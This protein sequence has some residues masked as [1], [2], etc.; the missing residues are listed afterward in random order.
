MG[1]AGLHQGLELRLKGLGGR[2]RTLKDR[3]SRAEGLQKIEALGLISRLEGRYNELK[4]RLDELNREGPG[5]RHGMKNELEK[6]TFDLSGALE[7][8]ITWADSG[9]HPDKHPA[10][11]PSSK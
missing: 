9:Y 3:M 10:E 5:F 7:N 2:I 4:D 6:L 11:M 1:Q 8:F